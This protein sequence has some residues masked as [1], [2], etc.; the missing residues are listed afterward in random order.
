ML[1]FFILNTIYL[2]KVT[3]F[4]GKISQFGFLVI[5]KK[6][7]YAYKLFLSNISDFIMWQ[8]HPSPWKKLPP[9]SQQ[10][11]C[12]SWG[13]V[14]PPFFKIWLEAHPPPP[15]ER[16]GCTTLTETDKLRLESQIT[17]LLT[18]HPELL[19]SRVALYFPCDLNHPWSLT[20]RQADRRD[21]QTGE[22][23]DKKTSMMVVVTHFKRLI[24]NIS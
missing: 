18:A 5:T 22:K 15:A 20:D 12:K 7:I 8:L 2:L 14:K 9:L 13:P 1:K 10:P 23:A 24:Y 19:N 17:L 3:K 21:K 6:N 4:L 11:H 16:E